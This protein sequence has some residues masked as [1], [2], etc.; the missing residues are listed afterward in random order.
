MPGTELDRWQDEAAMLLGEV[1][2]RMSDPAEA[3]EA[4]MRGILAAED[5]AAVFEM[6][7]TT[8]AK[9]LLDV[10]II[11]TDYRFMRSEHDDGAPVYALIDAARDDTGE[12]LKVTCGGRNVLA[13]LLTLGRLH[14]LPRRCKIIEAGKPTAR[15]FKPMWLQPVGANDGALS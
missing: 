3:A 14:A 2:V 11:V 12:A 9:E 6:A 13:Q 7:G 1:E 10:A 4:I 8:P 15:G 5:V